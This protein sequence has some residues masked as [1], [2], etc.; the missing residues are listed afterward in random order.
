MTEFPEN[1]VF[2]SLSELEHF[3]GSLILNLQWLMNNAF[4]FFT[5]DIMV[6]SAVEEIF[7]G[8][9]SDEET[10]DLLETEG[11]KDERRLP[12]HHIETSGLDPQRLN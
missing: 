9:E 8:S 12:L 5:F 4:T 3:E 10:D 6:C 11:E 2:H 1:T 7:E